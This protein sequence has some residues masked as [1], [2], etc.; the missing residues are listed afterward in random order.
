LPEPIKNWVHASPSSSIELGSVS[1]QPLGVV[2][3]MRAQLNDPG[4]AL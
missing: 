2:V 4:A 3:G 1:R